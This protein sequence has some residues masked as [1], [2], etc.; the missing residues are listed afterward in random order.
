MY[1][2]PYAQRLTLMTGF[3]I[4][5]SPGLLNL[6]GELDLDAAPDIV[7]AG[8]AA[9]DDSDTQTLLVNCD[10]VTFIDSSAI[11]A[12]VRLNTTADDQ[13]K[14]LALT[15]VPARVHQVLTITGLTE[16]FDIHTVFAIR[17]EQADDELGT[18]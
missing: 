13:G 14:H 18:G 17:P 1:S 12:L 10:A 7:E 11:G 15:N 5:C 6:S 3:H 2:A 4:S 9:L 8:L 16:V